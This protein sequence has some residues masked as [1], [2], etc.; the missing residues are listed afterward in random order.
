MARGDHVYV[1]RMGGLYSHHGI[2][3]GDGTVINYWPDGIPITSSVKRTAWGEF[4]DGGTV[5]LRHYSACDPPDTVIERALSAIGSG[6]FDPLTSNCEHFAVWCKTGRVESIQV[7]SAGSYLR[8]RPEAA[9]LAVMLAPMVV[10]M[11]V[12]AAFV[13]AVLDRNTN[14]L[15]R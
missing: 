11:A 14:R 3:C 8:Q 2:D 13:G 7:R 12:F 9:A 10:P 15:W 6:G 4:A 1:D 5:R